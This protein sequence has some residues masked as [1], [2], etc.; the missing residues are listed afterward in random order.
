[1]HRIPVLFWPDNGYPKRPDICLTRNEVFSKNTVPMK[2]LKK[3]PVDVKKIALFKPELILI[4]F[5]EI[6]LKS[7]CF[8]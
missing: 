4:V 3:L 1:M 6:R 8:F 7:I 5:K 2:Q